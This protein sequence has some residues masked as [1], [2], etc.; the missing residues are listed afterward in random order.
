MS[1]HKTRI[2]R[3]EIRHESLYVTE[4]LAD[5][6]FDF[7]LAQIPAHKVLLAS[8]SAVFADELT[9]K[10]D[11]YPLH[12][13]LPSTFLEFLQFFYLRQ[14][15]L[16]EANIEGVVHLVHRYDV[17]SAFGSCESFMKYTCTSEQVLRYYN[18]AIKY[19]LSP[20]TIDWLEETICFDPL[21]ILRHTNHIDMH[22]AAIKRLLS[23]NNWRTRE[24]LILQVALHLMEPKLTTLGCPMTGPN[25]RIALG[26][27]LALIGF[28]LM[29]MEELVKCEIQYPKLLSQE[30][31]FDISNYVVVKQS[32]TVAKHFRQTPRV[33]TFGMNL[34]NAKPRGCSEFPLRAHE[35]FFKIDKI[36]GY[37]SIALVV[38]A[39]H[40]SSSK[41]QRKDLQ[42]R[43]K[44]MQTGLV[45]CNVCSISKIRENCYPVC[46]PQA[47]QLTTD[48]T[49]QLSVL[50]KDFDL[51]PV[52]L[53][54]VCTSWPGFSMSVLADESSSAVF[55]MQFKCWNEEKTQKFK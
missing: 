20:K 6:H 28:P 13:V 37:T 15:E 22:D 46:L 50:D 24:V 35:L 8:K 41:N 43:I 1:G 19:D 2:Y 18:I 36:D 53:K 47:V 17:K 10:I 31:Y 23:S 32:L 30:E 7:N 38:I 4:T 25:L 34:L 29:N 51:G 27:H 21:E 5:I 14:V 9:G 33:R 54:P 16:T 49:Y 12:D 44:N 52:D 39:L 55:D 11:R 40:A 3:N 45:V 48:D 26:E 42:I